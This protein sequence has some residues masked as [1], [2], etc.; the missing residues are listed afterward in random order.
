MYGIPLSVISAVEGEWSASCPG[1]FT[2]CGI[3]LLEAEWT[4]KI[5]RDVL[6][7]MKFPCLYRESNYGPTSPYSRH[8][9]DIKESK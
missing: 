6:Q 1:S 7:K 3:R 2:T 8:Y 5:G 4:P 9:T